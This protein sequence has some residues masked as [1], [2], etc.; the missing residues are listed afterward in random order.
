MVTIFTSTPPPRNPGVS[1]FGRIQRSL[2]PESLAGCTPAAKE[3]PGFHAGVFHLW[4]FPI[5]WDRLFTEPIKLPNGRKL[6]TLRDAALY[7]T[8]LPKAEHDAEEWQAAM[9]ALMLVA[10]LEGPRNVRADWC[11]AGIEQ[12]RRARVQPI[13]QGSPLGAPQAGEGSMTDKTQNRNSG[14]PFR[15]IRARVGYRRELRHR[16]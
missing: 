10:E 2:C 3:N 8:K 4:S 13:A 9:E 12:P 6:V 1:Q 11:D 14:K 7:I 5:S 15:R 16:A